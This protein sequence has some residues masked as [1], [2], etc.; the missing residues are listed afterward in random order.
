[1]ESNLFKDAAT[2]FFTKMLRHGS[3]SAYYMKPK[4]SK[5]S[6]DEVIVIA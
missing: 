4:F 5:V 3:W 6:T 2:S 1:M